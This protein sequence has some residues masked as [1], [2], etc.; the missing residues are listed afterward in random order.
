MEKLL[1]SVIAL[2]GGAL[3]SAGLPGPW[4]ISKLLVVA[5]IGFMIVAADLMFKEGT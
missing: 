1:A 4:S 3:V 2:I 5:G